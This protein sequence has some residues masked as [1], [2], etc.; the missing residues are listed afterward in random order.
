MVNTKK[1]RPI[2]PFEELT[3]SDDYLFKRIMIEKDIC[4]RF[5]ESLLQVKIRDIKYIGVEQVFKETYL[6]KGIR[7]DVYVEDDKN[8]IYNIEMQTPSKDNK[9]LGKRIRYYQ[10]L[11]DSAILNRGD[12]YKK[13]KNLYIIFICTF[14]L[15]R[16]K[17]QVY[18]FKNYCSDDKNIKLEDGVTK[19]IISTK[20]KEEQNLDKDLKAFIDYVNGILPDNDFIQ[21]VNIRIG[22]IKQKESERSLY[23]QYELRLRDEREA[24][25]L[26]GRLEGRQENLVENIR[27]FMQ[28]GGLSAEQVMKILQISEEQ[29]GLYL[30]LLNDP[31]FYEEYFSEAE[32]DEEEYDDYDEDEE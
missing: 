26:E 14:A 22:E 24:G 10:S 1:Q 12:D 32:Y 20:G 18:F 6:G 21:T 2:K 29:Q 4:M 16:C 25:R 27:L 3:I 13:L 7:L 30:R 28:N 17:R 23:M 8:T 5:L 19:I 31:A 9:Y 15:F 11:I